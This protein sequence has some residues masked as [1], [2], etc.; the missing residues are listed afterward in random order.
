M[1]YRSLPEHFAEVSP[2]SDLSLF[3][4]AVTTPEYHAHGVKRN[5]FLSPL[6]GLKLMLSKFVPVRLSILLD[7]M[8]SLNL[9]TFSNTGISIM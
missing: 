8:A 5:G 7:A 6:Q 9:L 3:G 4:H 2:A 1:I